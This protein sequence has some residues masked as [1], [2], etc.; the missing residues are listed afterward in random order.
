MVAVIPAK[1]Q[2]EIAETFKEHNIELCDGAMAMIARVG[3]EKVGSAV[4]SIVNNE[5]TLLSVLYPKED[6]GLCDLISRAAM[7]Y[8]VNRNIM[9]CELG[10]KAP[11]KEF[12]T[13]GFIKN[14]EET[15]IDIIK[16]FTLCTNCKK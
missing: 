15:T 10:E 6:I 16:T 1:N 13:L 3:D 9:Y 4:F 12:Y 11:K 7:N 5:M 8:G 2:E 14:S